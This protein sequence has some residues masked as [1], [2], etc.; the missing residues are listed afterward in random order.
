MSQPSPDQVEGSNDVS[1]V[2]AEE[3]E[4]ER[5]DSPEMDAIDDAPGTDDDPGERDA[6][7]RR[8]S[9]KNPDRPERQAARYR[10]Q[11]NEARRERDAA[12][13]ERDELR[14]RLAFTEAA[15]A[16]FVMYDAA[17]KLVDRS[18]LNLDVDGTPVGAEEAVEALA[19]SNP[20]LLAPTARVKAEPEPFTSARSS[21]RMMNGRRKPLVTGPTRA[22]LEQRF[23]ALRR[24]R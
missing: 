9:P 5:Q 11:R 1:D 21:G 12:I 18:I 22:Q 16:R 7:K 17:W 19:E 2:R 15:G 8:G 6:R 13:E 3:Q 4:P 20:F 10:V 14:L 24:D 23:P